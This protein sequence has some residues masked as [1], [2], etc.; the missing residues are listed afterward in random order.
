M[1]TWET[2]FGRCSTAP[3]TPADTMVDGVGHRAKCRTCSL[4]TP[5]RPHLDLD[6]SKYMI[7][8]N[9]TS[10]TI[11]LRNPPLRP[12]DYHGH[13]YTAM[14]IEQSKEWA[15]AEV[16]MGVKV[17]E[18]VSWND[19]SRGVAAYSVGVNTVAFARA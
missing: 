11:L 4:Y 5:A 8:T 18:A 1:T 17:V 16:V 9:L 13:R 15:F 6:H 3:T 19:R 2:A 7:S 10:T 14:V 12:H